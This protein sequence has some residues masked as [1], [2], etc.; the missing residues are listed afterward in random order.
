MVSLRQDAQATTALAYVGA[1]VVVDG[2]TAQ[3]ANGRATWSFNV[4]KPATATITIKDSAGQTVYTGTFTVNPGDQKFTWDGK[5]SNGKQWPDGN[6]TLTAT[7]VDANGRRSPVSTEIQAMVDFGRP[8]QIR[9]CCPSTGGL[10]DH[11]ISRSSPPISE[12]HYWR[13]PRAARASAL[14]ATLVAVAVGAHHRLDRRVP[15][16]NSNGLRRISKRPSASR[17]ASLKPL[18]NSTGMFG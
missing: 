11:Q 5:G 6:Y 9:R 10:H 14:Y 18:V 7:A 2:S 17:A 16:R 8:H 15:A 4:T 1:T 13:G 3:L 12:R